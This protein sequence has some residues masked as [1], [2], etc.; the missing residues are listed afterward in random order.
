MRGMFQ[1]CKSLTTIN[2][3]N[4]DTSNVTN[5]W[6]MF[7]NC[8]SLKELDLSNFTTSKVTNMES[9]FHACVSMTEL[10]LSNFTTAESN[11]K[12]MFM[13][14]EKIEILNI[15]NFDFQNVNNYENI[16]KQIKSN[17]KIIVKDNTQK[18]WLNT[19]FSNL[20]NIVVAD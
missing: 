7:L 14:C 9:M 18:N 5:M 1:N 6:R 10:D 11:L 8:S 17:V 3:L 12:G 15:R 16:F 19:N 4:F 13:Y 2:L 20:T